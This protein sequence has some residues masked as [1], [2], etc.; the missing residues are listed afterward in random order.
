VTSLHER[1]SF[2]LLYRK[3]EVIKELKYG[4][5]NDL[6]YLLQDESGKKYLLRRSPETKKY[7]A[8]RNLA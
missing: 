7:H 6:K 1:M 2:Y 4:W 5:S 3:Y 8:R